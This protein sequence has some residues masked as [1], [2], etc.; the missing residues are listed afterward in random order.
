MSRAYREVEAVKTSIQDVRNKTEVFHSRVK[1]HAVLMAQ[2]LGI[3]ETKPRVAGRQLHRANIP[4]Q[5]CTGYYRFN[6]TIIIR[7][8]TICYLNTQP[9]L[10]PGHQN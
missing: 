1:T 8:L 5:S 4:A 2:S 10:M 7:L 3:E 6:L 9:D